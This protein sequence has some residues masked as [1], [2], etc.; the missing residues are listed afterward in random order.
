MKPYLA[1]IRYSEPP[2]SLRVYGKLSGDDSLEN[3]DFKRAAT[4]IG[5]SEV[6]LHIDCP[7]GYS[8][9]LN[10]LKQLNIR[11]VYVHGSAMSAG[12][13]MLPMGKKRIVFQTARI[14]FHV[15]GWTGIDGTKI[16]SNGD[17]K[18]RL[19]SFDLEM[20]EMYSKFTKR[21]FGFYAKSMGSMGDT[22][23]TPFN[24]CMHGFADEILSLPPRM[25]ERIYQKAK[26]SNSADG[27][28]LA[29]L[30]RCRSE[31]SGLKYLRHANV[32][33]TAEHIFW[34]DWVLKNMDNFWSYCLIG[35][36]NEEKAL[37]KAV[38]QLKAAV[39]KLGDSCERT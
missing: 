26:L 30:E 8:D 35:S 22:F 34:F 15:S 2:H 32:R 9:R 36:C 13:F 24:S 1:V 10:P 19:D 27:I 7:G 25:V 6:D 17:V 28:R 14:M 18:K 23:L 33:E 31:Y 5:R 29:C 20:C 3:S 12:T 4:E 11:N 37:M 39:K 16:Y 21:S 38:E